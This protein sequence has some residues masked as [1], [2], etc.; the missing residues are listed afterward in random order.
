[1]GYRQFIVVRDK[2]TKEEKEEFQIP[3]YLDERFCVL[4]IDLDEDCSFDDER[5]PENGYYGTI[6]ELATFNDLFKDYFRECLRKTIKNFK[7][8]E[9]VDYFEYVFFEE[10]DCLGNKD[11]MLFTAPSYS[12]LSTC[13]CFIKEMKMYEIN[14][15][16]KGYPLYDKYEFYFTH[17]WRS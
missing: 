9:K 6:I 17:G 5:N 8:F 2:E 13:I 16:F 4:G 3:L 12:F 14:G 10:P 1:M 15:K 11:R 7:E